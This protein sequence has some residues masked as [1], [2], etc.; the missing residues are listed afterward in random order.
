[1]QIT[2]LTQNEQIRGLGGKAVQGTLSGDSTK[3]PGRRV[4]QAEG[5]QCKGAEE[6]D[7]WPSRW[8]AR[9]RGQ[10]TGST[11][12]GYQKAPEGAERPGT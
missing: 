11:K 2:R 8:P 12:R 4:F 3:T 1:M 6:E 7:A 10:G 9:P 5:H